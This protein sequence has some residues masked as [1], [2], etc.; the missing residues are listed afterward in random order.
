VSQPEHTHAELLAANTA[1]TLATSRQHELIEAIKSSNLRL[2]KEIAERKQVET[3]LR[4]SEERFRALF[5]SGPVAV[6]FC[7][8]SG[9]ILEFNHRAAVLW[10]RTPALGDTD[11]KFCGSF[12]L[13][14]PDGSF[15]PHEKC[16]M[17]EVISGKIREARDAEVLIE[18]PDGSRITVIVNILPLTNQRGEVRGAINSFYDITDRKKIEERQQ[19]VTN[20]LAHRG[21]NLLAVIQAIASRSL[22]CAPSLAEGREVLMRRLQALARS[23]SLLLAENFEGAPITEI[24][25][26]EFEAFSNRVQTAGPEIILNPKAA[27][28]FALLVHELATNATKHGA[29]SLPIGKVRVRWSVGAG[30][31]ARFKFQ[32]QERDGPRV[33]PPTHQGFGRIVLEKAAAQDFG[34]PP[35][36]KFMPDGLSYEI[37]APLSAVEVPSRERGSL[38]E[39]DF[40]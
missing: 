33:V 14:R 1:L 24:I 30:A 2:Q 21:N 32:W 20:E 11:E 4:E 6:Y 39:S 25:R 5:A 13:F 27:Q 16:P 40:A 12:K 35:K 29:L 31:K 26:L 28:T 38:R 17:A 3:A 22:S 18:R 10:G 9:V 19:L 7:D 8:T 23:Q 34:A 36:I 37:D 15:M